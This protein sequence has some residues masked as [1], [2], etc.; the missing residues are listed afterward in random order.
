VVVHQIDGTFACLPV[1]MI[2][3]A[4]SR[5]EIGDEPRFPLEVLRSLCS[6]ADALLGFLA[7]ESKT[8]RQEHDAAIREQPLASSSISAHSAG[9]CGEQHRNG[10]PDHTSSRP[11]SPLRRYNFPKCTRRTK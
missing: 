9:T 3:E 2:D 8:E 10:E 1:W 6:E 5:V 11:G 4:A 7:S